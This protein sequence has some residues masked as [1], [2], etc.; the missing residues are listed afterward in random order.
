MALK[1]RCWGALKPPRLDQLHGNTAIGSS[2][3]PSA[4][5]DKRC[6]DKGWHRKRT[7]ENVGTGERMAEMGLGGT[8]LTWFLN[9]ML[10]HPVLPGHQADLAA[11]TGDGEEVGAEL[12]MREPTPSQL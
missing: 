12:R 6:G 5:R 11:N 2:W 3:P 7:R 9:H 10:I 8:L 1:S 4:D